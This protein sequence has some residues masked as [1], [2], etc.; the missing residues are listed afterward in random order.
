MQWAMYQRRRLCA[1][2]HCFTWD[3]DRAERNSR[4]PAFSD[5]FKQYA[6][7]LGAATGRYE[8]G[9]ERR[10]PRISFPGNDDDR[11]ALSDLPESVTEAMK[12]SVPIVK[13]AKRASRFCEW[14]AEPSCRNQRVSRLLFTLHKTVNNIARFRRI[15]L[16][17][18]FQ[19]KIRHPR[20][21]IF[22][23]R[24]L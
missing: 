18:Y 4:K 3:S 12:V 21:R 2:A 11:P 8:V 5:V 15:F 13:F 19:H 1:S 23:R 24:L 10:Y 7:K 17:F 14:R 6:R 16:H 22:R 20:C 9:N